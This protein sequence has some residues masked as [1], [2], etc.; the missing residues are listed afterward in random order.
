MPLASD[1]GKDVVNNAAKDAIKV[2]VEDEED[3]LIDD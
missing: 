3:E 1:D 2:G